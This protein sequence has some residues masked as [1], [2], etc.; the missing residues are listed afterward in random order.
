MLTVGERERNLMWKQ[1]IMVPHPGK[2]C[3]KLGMEERAQGAVGSRP[4]DRGKL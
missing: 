2:C 1:N 4:E 3:V